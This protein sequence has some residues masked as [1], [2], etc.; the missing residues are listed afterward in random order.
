MR[1]I[2]IVAGGPVDD[3]PSFHHYPHIT[4]WIGVDSGAYKL[5]QSFDQFDY[6]IGDFDS[7]NDD[8]L[9]AIHEACASV[10]TYPSDKD[11]TD[12]ELAIKLAISLDPDQVL[13]FGALG[14][15]RDHEWVNMFMLQ[16]FMPHHIDAWLVNKQNEITLK[17]PG[18][19]HIER[20]DTFPY[21]SFLALTR[22]VKGLTLEGFK[23]PLKDQTI[24]SGSS[25]TVSNEWKEKIGTYLFTDGILIV[26]KSRDG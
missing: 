20:D 3:M 17:Q 8:E 19:Y 10:H 24:Q 4:T 9:A 25:L 15:R 16:S 22:T 21:V 14:G 2:A 23:Y 5:S 26:I 11:D 1:V 12:L 6:A 18:T 13:V 7:V